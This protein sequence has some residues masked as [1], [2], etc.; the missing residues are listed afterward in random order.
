[1][2]AKKK[3]VQPEQGAAITKAAPAPQV[4]T[5]EIRTDKVSL[6]VCAYPGTE[7]K[8]RALWERALAKTGHAF[9]VVTVQPEASG[10]NVVLPAILADTEIADVFVC[11]PANTFPT[12]DIM[13]EELRLP[14]VYV[15]KDGKRAYHHRLPKLFSKDSVAE[16]LSG[17]EMDDEA[18]A[19]KC[20]S[21][22]SRPVEVGHSFGNF[23][24][25]VL[26]GNPCEHEVIKAMLPDH[27]RKY[28]AVTYQGWQAVEHLVDEFLLKK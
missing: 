27:G 1:M 5:S 7:E 21:L 10:L 2:T 11:V 9:K 12:S 18:L 20:A 19:R 14:V 28:V 25:Q 3:I 6:V 4:E 22:L 17:P 24:T 8:M 13:V 26:R 15:R 23:V 16:L